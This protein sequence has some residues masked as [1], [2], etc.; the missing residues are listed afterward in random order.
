[1]GTPSATSWP[2]AFAPAFCEFGNSRLKLSWQQQVLAIS[3]GQGMEW[4][5]H[6]AAL[7]SAS[8]VPPLL[9]IATVAPQR[10]ATLLSRLQQYGIACFVCWLQELFPPSNPFLPYE[11]IRGIG[12]DR[13]LGLLGARRSFPPPLMTVDCGTAVTVNVL[14]AEGQCLGG[15]IFASAPVQLRALGAATALIPA[16]S[17]QPTFTVSIGR[18]TEEALLNGTWASVLGGIQHL[19]ESFSSQLLCSTP[20][21]IILTGGGSASLL[22][23]LQ[24]WWKGTVAY[25]PH[26]VLEGMQALVEQYTSEELQPYVQ[27]LDAVAL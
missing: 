7:L 14:S 4:A 9:F 5:Y 21:A 19:I 20:P 13:L 25:R 8:P 10:T 6:T 15:A 2:N 23:P 26:L 11:G 18:T 22:A 27:P 3:Y 12:I 1:M 16:V 17:P 24:R